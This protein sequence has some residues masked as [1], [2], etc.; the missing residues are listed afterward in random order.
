[1]LVLV[2]NIYAAW[3]EKK[4]Y[5]A[6]FMDITG[7]F[8]NVHHGRLIHNMKKRR[9]PPQ[10]TRWI[11]SFLTGRSTQLKFNGTTSESFV[12]LAGVPQGSPLSPILYIFYNADLLD[13][14]H[15][16]EL[17]LGFIDD[18]GYGV[19]GATAAG[20]IGKLAN[21]LEKA[22][23][24]R[25]KHGAQ[26]EK[27]KYVLI[28]FTRNKATN[29]DASITVDGITIHPADEAK[30][31]GV[32]FDNDLKYRAHVDQIV[33]KGTK[34]ALAIAGIAKSTWGA[35]FKHL[36]RLF[37]AVAAPRMDYAAIIWHRPG[38][39]RTAPTQTQVRKL[40][41][42]QRQIMRAITGCFH[43]T[44]T[45]ALEAETGLPPPKPPPLGENPPVNHKNANR[46]TTTPNPQV[47]CPSTERQ[48]RVFLSV[49]P[50]KPRKAL[51]R[52]H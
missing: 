1:M 34:F 20:N 37:T 23:T 16:E 43:T 38:D 5:S 10:L 44:P 21:M 2:E 49:K 47:G 19:K 40:S 7:A 12:T 26:F 17:G 51:P 13:I 42:V 29:T 22:E 4:T 18:I 25:Q 28:H 50:R 41:T 45:S 46:P 8:N 32:I 31:L 11:Q 52:V 35:K 3:R 14:P 30:Y 33:K 15:H 24:W 36:R 27:S 9:I 48:S 6:I 39:N